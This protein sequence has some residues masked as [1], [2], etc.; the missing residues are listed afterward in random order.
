[1]ALVA[2]RCD[3]ALEAFKN[4]QSKH[5]L[6]NKYGFNAGG[7][8]NPTATLATLGRAELRHATKVQNI[9]GLLALASAEH[10]WNLDDVVR[11]Q[12]W[13][14]YNAIAEGGLLLLRCLKHP[15]CEPLAYAFRCDRQS[16]SACRPGRTARTWSWHEALARK[17]TSYSFHATAERAAQ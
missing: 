3:R 17:T 15:K 8:D 10:R 16:L 4:A 7:Y 11:L 6:I 13:E 14:R 1:M 9:D 5:S 2:N 12:A